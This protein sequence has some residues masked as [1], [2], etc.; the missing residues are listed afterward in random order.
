MAKEAR[1]HRTEKFTV[2]PHP[3]A[4]HI[5]K[6]GA[7]A[8]TLYYLLCKF[9][10]FESGE[11]FPKIE[12]LAKLA[13]CSRRS[14]FR[15][16]EILEENGL[17]T[18][19][20]GVETGSFNKYWITP[21]HQLPQGGGVPKQPYGCA[22]TY[23]G[24]VAD[25]AH[26]N[27]EELEPTNENQE[28]E[29]GVLFETAP[30]DDDPIP[31]VFAYFVEKTG[32]TDQYTLTSARYRMAKKRWDEEV[33]MCRKLKVHEDRIRATVGIHFRN[34]IDELSDSEYHRKNGY[35][36]WEQLFESREKLEKWIERYA[37]EYSAN[38][39]TARRSA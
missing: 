3:I 14:V 17:V 32:K 6:I 35:L 4:D 18:R 25:L 26:P 12:T 10:D 19:E 37:S 11:C 20:S 30:V 13:G 1:F 5:C 34:V 31:K 36:D 22:K 16:I 8:F 38:Q 9:A 7:A 23:I 21:S 39:K 33:K 15:S 28:Q 2:I 27:K 24:G 29:P